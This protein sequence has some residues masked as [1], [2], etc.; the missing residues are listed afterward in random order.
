MG[1]AAALHDPGNARLP[2]RYCGRQ[3]A[4]RGSL[5]AQPT[6][7]RSF[8]SARPHR[9]A[10]HPLDTKHPAIRE[11]PR[12]IARTHGEPARH[13]AALT[14]AEI[15]RLVDTCLDNHAGLR[16]RAMLL[17]G[18]AGGLR[19]SKLVAPDVEQFLPMQAGFRVTITRAKMDNVG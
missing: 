17:L 19:S 4:S 2:Q 11:T 18:L 7:L 12:V 14:T 1:R 15:T 6:L 5:I 9:V 3:L 8:R 10:L 13:S 16:D